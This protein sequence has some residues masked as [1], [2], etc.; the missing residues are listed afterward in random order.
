MIEIEKVSP[1]FLL[2]SPSPLWFVFVFPKQSLSTQPWLSWNSGLGLEASDSEIHLSLPPHARMKGVC[3]CPSPISHCFM[4]IIHYGSRCKS[5]GRKFLRCWDCSDE[6]VEKWVFLEEMIM[7]VQKVQHGAREQ[8]ST[9]PSQ[10]P[11]RRLC[12]SSCSVAVRESLP[13][14]AMLMSLWLANWIFECCPPVVSLLL[15]SSEGYQL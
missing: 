7:L 12:W 9:V 1:P 5:R 14:V 6:N 15:T 11:G 3:P 10:K 4:E 2:H 13:S 8:I